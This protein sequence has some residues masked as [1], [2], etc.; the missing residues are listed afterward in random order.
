MAQEVTVPSPSYEEMLDMRKNSDEV[1][2]ELRKMSVRERDESERGEERR[3]VREF[4]RCERRENNI[5][6][7]EYRQMRK[8]CITIHW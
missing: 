1:I 3:M 7:E 6:Y 2:R 4:V 5:S 8:V